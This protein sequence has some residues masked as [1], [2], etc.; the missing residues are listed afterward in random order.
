METIILPTPTLDSPPPS[1]PAH[2]VGQCL[3]SLQSAPVYCVRASLF[4]FVFD[5]CCSDHCSRL[6]LVAFAFTLVYQASSTVTWP[7]SKTAVNMPLLSFPPSQSAHHHQDKSRLLSM[8]L[9]A[10]RALLCGPS[11]CFTLTFII[12]SIQLVPW[13]SGPELNAIP[14]TSSGLSPPP[15]SRKT[16]THTTK[17]CLSMTNLT[18]ILHPS[19]TPQL[20]L[21]FPQHTPDGW[22]FLL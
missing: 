18:R 7:L 6:L 22:G 11:Q 1:S 12:P 20:E 13:S 2:P 14:S 15:A 21:L 8:A 19:S 9:W 4:H 10:S 17:L 5:D 16:P 3:N